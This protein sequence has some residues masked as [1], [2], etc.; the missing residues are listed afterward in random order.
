M[1]DLDWLVLTGFLVFIVVYGVWKSRGSKNVTCY[2][3]TDHSTRWPTIVLSIMA[4][5]ASAITF[6][7][8]PGQ[9]FVDGMRFLQFYLGL[10]IAMVVLSVTAV[11]IFQRLQVFCVLISTRKPADDMNSTPLISITILKRPVSVTSSSAS[12]NCGAV[13]LSTRPFTPTT[14]Q[15]LC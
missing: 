5:Q 6:L 4:T 8:T 7:S 13:W 9:A 15:R 10:P 3:L 11:P 14:S 12:A 2:L 1:N